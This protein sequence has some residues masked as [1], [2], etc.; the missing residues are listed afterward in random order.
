M[1]AWTWALAPDGQKKEHDDLGIAFDSP[2]DRVDR[3]NETGTLLRQALHGE[4]IQPTPH[5]PVTATSVNPSIDVAPRLL[6]GGHG[7]RLLRG[8]APWADIIQLTGVTDDRQGTLRVH[9]ATLA[10]FERRIA[11]IREAAPERFPSIKLS[12]L[13]QRATVT[14]S[15][16]ETASALTATAAEFSCSEQFLR[17]SPIALIGT[18]EEIAEKLRMLRS[19][20]GISHASI[21]AP[22]AEPF[23]AVIDLLQ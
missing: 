14:N 15:V 17:E 20:L 9:E 1:I 4:P 22:A 11:W 21:F 18:A 7:P 3:L 6:T 10:D 8:C 12:L 19:Q 16:S 13:V 23:A 2:R 5:Y